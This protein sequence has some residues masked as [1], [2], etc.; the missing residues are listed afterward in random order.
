MARSVREPNDHVEGMWQTRLRTTARDLR[1]ARTMRAVVQQIERVAARPDPSLRVVASERSLRDAA[2]IVVFPGSFNP[3]TLA[4]IGLVETALAAGYDAALWLLAVTSVD[5]ERVERA[6]LTDR[7]AQM[8][9]Y[10]RG[11]R[12][13][14]LALTNRGL[15][16]EQARLLHRRFIATEVSILVG[17]DK[18][19]QIFDALLRRPRRRPER[20][21]RECSPTCRATRWRGPRGPGHAA[22]AARKPALRAASY[23]SG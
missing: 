18:L 11:S 1:S 4:H 19:T 2:R 8:S 7:V 16:F 12:A 17:F 13:N 10:V 21:L 5:K 20:A 23:L 6:A 15:Y 9:A 22:G 3:L 14:A